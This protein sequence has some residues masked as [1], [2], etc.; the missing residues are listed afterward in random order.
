[1]PFQPS[2][3][4]VGEDRSL[5]K[6]IDHKRYFTRVGATTLSI[7]TLSVLSTTF[8]NWDTQHIETQHNVVYCYAE[9]H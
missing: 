3:M 7:N 8:K 4:F 9:C 1:M 5:I 2:L 6:I